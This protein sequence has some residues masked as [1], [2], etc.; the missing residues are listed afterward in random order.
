[1][2]TLSD[3]IQTIRQVATAAVGGESS[4]EALNAAL[5]AL[6]ERLDAAGKNLAEDDVGHAAFEVA[7]A[8]T[9]ASLARITFTQRVAGNQAGHRVMAAHVP[10]LLADLDVAC[11]LS[12]AG[13]TGAASF[14]SSVGGGTGAARLP[15]QSAWR[16][17]APR[18]R[19]RHR[20]ALAAPQTGVPV[21]L[22]ARRE[23]PHP[24]SKGGNLVPLSLNPGRV[25]G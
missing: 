1:M 5:D 19:L 2:S 12:A 25:E 18:R 16:Q 14:C 9:F 6:Q 10:Q 7:A 22:K 23:L 4:P 11:G 13:N 3:T 24:L 8:K 15:C 21:G 17:A 20:G